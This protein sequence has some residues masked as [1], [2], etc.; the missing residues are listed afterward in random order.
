MFISFFFL[1]RLVYILYLFSHGIFLCFFPFGDVDSSFQRFISNS[2]NVF[3]FLVCSFPLEWAAIYRLCWDAGGYKWQQ[4]PSSPSFF[5]SI[6]ILEM[7]FPP[8]FR[9]VVS[10]SSKTSVWALCA[11]MSTDFLLTKSKQT[12]KHWQKSKFF[13]KIS[14]FFIHCE[15]SPYWPKL[16]STILKQQTSRF[17]FILQCNKKVSIHVKNFT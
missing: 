15:I 17:L 1:F 16:S 5:K 13:L 9:S 8:G 4:Q 7:I 10:R 14:F 11:T 6:N 2:W 3:S 12:Q